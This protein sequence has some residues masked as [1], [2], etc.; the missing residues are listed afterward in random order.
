MRKKLF[1]DFETASEAELR[2]AKSVGVYNYFAHKSTRILMLAWAFENEEPEV[3]EPHLGPIPIRLIEGLKNPEVDIVSFN[4]TFERLGFRKLGFEIPISRM[5]DPQASARYLSLPGKLEEVSEIL[6]LPLE[7]AKEKR[8]KQLIEL[9]SKPHKKKKKRGEE[10]EWEF[11][12]YNSHPKEWEEFKSYAKQDI[13]SEREVLRREELLGVWPLPLNERKIWEFDQ[14]V[15][16]R[17]IPVDRD[18]VTKAYA[19]ADREK[20]EVIELNN[21]KTGLD[22]SNSNPQMLRWART[23]GY[24]GLDPDVSEGH[25]DYPKYS[26][27]KDVVKSQL[28]N[29]QELTPLCREVLENRQ[30]TSSTTYKKL[31]AILRQVSEDD[32]VRGQFVYMGSSRCGR[33]S[34]AGV[35]VHNLA[36][37]NDVFEDEETIDRA[38]A[39]IY[40]MDYEGIKKEFGSVLLTVKF[41]IRTAFVAKK[42]NK[43]SVSDLNAI[44]TRAGAW[45]AGCKPLLDVFAQNRDPYVDFGMKIFQIPYEILIRDLKS[46]DPAVKAAAKKIRQIAKPG[47]LGCLGPDT[48]IQTN[49]GWVRIIDLNSDDLLFDGVDWVSYKKVLDK[50]I[51]G[52]VDLNGVLVTPNHKILTGKKG[53]KSAWDV[54]QNSHL[55]NQAI[56]LATGLLSAA[57][58]KTSNITMSVTADD[59]EFRK[60]FLNRIWKG[61]KQKL[62]NSVLQIKCKKKRMGF[63]SDFLNTPAKLLIDWQTDIT[64][65]FRGVEER[66]AQAIVMG[67][68]VFHAPLL[69]FMNFSNTYSSFQTSTSLNINSIERI[70]TGITKKEIYGLLPSKSIIE[71]KKLAVSS[72]SKVRDI[73]QQNSGRNSLLNIEMSEMLPVP[74]ETDLRESKL[75]KV[76]PSVEVR[77]YDILDSGP[78]S[79]YMILTDKG[80][81]LVHNCIYRMSATTLQAYAEAMGV[82]MSLEQAEQVVKVFREAY[83]EIVQAWFDLEEKIK[84]VLQGVKVVRY[85]G[86][87]DCIKI[88]KFV[89]TCNGKPRTILRIWLP[90][91]RCLHY[92]DAAWEATTMPWE[93]RETGEQAVRDAFNYASQDQK[94]KQWSRTSSHGGKVFENIDQGLSRDLLAEKLLKF[95]AIMPVVLHVHDEGV[96]ENEDDPFAPGLA[97]MNAIMAEPIEWAPGLPLGSDGFEGFYYRKN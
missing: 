80:P 56:N 5:Q 48:L 76:N 46:K 33:W 42:G 52:V 12:D 10:V 57:T 13:V 75:L 96:G 79:R 16:D 15:N 40:N 3:W 62:V 59:A 29:N 64:Q 90:S 89:F 19:L 70:I 83:K 92:V 43:F 21:Q 36:K 2:G 74:L 84:E 7:L 41:N 24:A 94:T 20:K 51:R 27:E 37:S 22:N 25:K 26:L 85:F 11:Y 68:E 9:F 67:A 8:G 14:K 44:E 77:T 38:R 97:E 1:T 30:S 50:G 23:Q 65:F 47:V 39:M 32:R 69:L 66:V 54:S 63:I 73:V 86:P 91:G 17:G 93:D 55:E 81:M 45:L 58:T 28:K 18:F 87:N 53:W 78:N 61:V 88:D 31:S 4:S 71:T 34:G 49:R 82:I 95:E 72:I 35:Q 6:G 60:S